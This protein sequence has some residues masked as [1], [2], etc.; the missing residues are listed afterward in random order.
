MRV[1]NRANR[2]I[3]DLHLSGTFGPGRCSIVNQCLDARF[4]S[5]F[6]EDFQRI[7]RKKAESQELVF[8][9]AILPQSR[10]PLGESQHCAAPNQRSCKRVARCAVKKARG[11][12]SGLGLLAHFGALQVVLLFLCFVRGSSSL[13]TTYSRHEEWRQRLRVSRRSFR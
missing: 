10:F 1:G 8:H 4:H 3:Q 5:H 2:P 13:L 9:F 11:T 12:Y 7:I 6:P